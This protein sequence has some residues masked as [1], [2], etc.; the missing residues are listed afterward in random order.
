M[1]R[2]YFIVFQ[3]NLSTCS[4]RTVW[5][6]MP[7]LLSADWT[8]YMRLRKRSKGQLVLKAIERRPIGGDSIGLIRIE[9]KPDYTPSFVRKSTAR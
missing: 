4:V 7:P 6:I 3:L 2:R 9:N 5:S 1:T 8:L